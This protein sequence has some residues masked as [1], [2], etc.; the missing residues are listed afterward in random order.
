M[1]SFLTVPNR[2]GWYY[3]AIKKHS[4][5]LRGISSKNKGL[6]YCLNSFRAKDKL[7]S[8]KKV[9][10]NKDFCNNVLP[11]E[12]TKILGF[13]Q[14]KKSEKASFIIYPDLQCL[15]EKIDGCKNNPEYL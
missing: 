6:F 14:Q 7:Q 13:D 11:S 15:I 12:D 3:L 10:G 8:H 2:E 4:V 1:L 5:L 9:C